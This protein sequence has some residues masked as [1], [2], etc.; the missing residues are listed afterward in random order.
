METKSERFKRVATRRVQEILYKLRLLG[1]CSNTGVYSYT[2]EDTKKIF[3][4]L[5]KELKIVKLKFSEKKH[6]G[7]QL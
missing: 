1:N 2:D 6:R 4:T 3:L 7:F 5:E